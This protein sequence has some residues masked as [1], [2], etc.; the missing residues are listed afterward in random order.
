MKKKN[1]IASEAGVKILEREIPERFHE[2]KVF[3]EH[4]KLKIQLEKT[5]A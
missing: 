5:I 2:P 4:N 1:L 3:E